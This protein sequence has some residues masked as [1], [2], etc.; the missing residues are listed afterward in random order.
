VALPLCTGY[1][2]SAARKIDVVPFEGHHLPAP[3]PRLTAQQHNDLSIRVSSCSGHEP[4]KGTKSWN[5]A[6]V[7][8]V[9][10]HLIAKGQLL[11]TFHSIAFR[12]MTFSTVSTLFTVFADLPVSL[13]SAAGH[14]PS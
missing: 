9:R 14:P 13:D 8:A 12:K 4:F 11:I 6:S 10:I 5:C 3:Q 1:A 2:E 7:F